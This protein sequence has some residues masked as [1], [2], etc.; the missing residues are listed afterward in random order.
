V[1]FDGDEPAF[2]IVLHDVPRRNYERIEF[3]IGVDAAANRS[4][5]QRGDLDP[6]GRMAW[7]WEV[8]YKFVLFEGALLRGNASDP[9]VYHVGFEENY[10]PTS[11]KLPRGPF[12]SRPARLDFRV[13]LLRLFQGSTN[14]DMAALPS[15]KF[16]RTDAALLARNF[17]A[18]LTPMWTKAAGQPDGAR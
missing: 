12:D 18:M 4:L 7:N 16:D 5:M 8:G 9:L 6:N 17:A 13:D 1:R 14:I 11:T 2:V 15:V 10:R 3:G